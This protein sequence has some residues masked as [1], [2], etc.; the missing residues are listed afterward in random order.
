MAVDHVILKE[1]HVERQVPFFQ[2][3]LRRY[4]DAPF[5]VELEQDGR[6]RCRAGCCA[7][8]GRALRE[9]RERRLEVAS[10][11]DAQRPA[12]HAARL[13]R[14][15]LAAGEGPV[16]PRDEGRR[17]R[18]GARPAAH[19]LE[20]RR[21]RRCEVHFHDFAR[22]APSSA[23]RAG[24]VHRDDRRAG[25]RDHRLRPALG[26]VRRRRAAARRLPDATTTPRALHARLAGE[27]HRRRPATVVR[28]AR[29]WAGTAEKTAAS[30]RSSSAPA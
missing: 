20:R 14:L 11:C 21:R 2:D 18:R 6:A 1:F 3:Y 9:R 16:E 10:S 29:E 30:A 13:A 25:G 17:R 27:V 19:L 15:P 26:A 12:A 7:R 24:A 5:L 28:F 23:R 22:P 8:A 4:S